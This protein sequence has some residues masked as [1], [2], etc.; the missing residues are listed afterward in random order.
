MKRDRDAVEIK[1]QIAKI[2]GNDEEGDFDRAKKLFEE[3]LL[4]NP[5]LVEAHHCLGLLM[6]T[7]F[8]EP[9]TAKSLFRKANSVIAS[10]KIIF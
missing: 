7:R 2:I 9:E 6:W 10:V 4:E 3:V 8:D 1:Y 5:Q